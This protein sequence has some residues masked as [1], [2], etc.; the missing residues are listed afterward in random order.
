VHTVR[1]AGTEA[2]PRRK[3]NA[4]Y[5]SRWLELDTLIG[6]WDGADTLTLAADFVWRRGVSGIS[7]PARAAPH[8]TRRGRQFAAALPAGG[9]TI[10]AGGRLLDL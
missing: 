3:A 2:A 5:P 8:A 10:A 7:Y 4:G 6:T 9:D 1:S